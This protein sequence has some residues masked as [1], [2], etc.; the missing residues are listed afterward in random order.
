MTISNFLKIFSEYIY[1]SSRDG[2]IEEIATRLGYVEIDEDFVKICDSGDIL[3]SLLDAGSD[4]YTIEI[5]VN[6]DN[7]NFVDK[8][9]ETPLAHAI[10]CRRYDVAEHLMTLDMEAHL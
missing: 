7:I 4:L 6:N 5:F 3:H 8:N 9:G 10:R 2:K 1:R